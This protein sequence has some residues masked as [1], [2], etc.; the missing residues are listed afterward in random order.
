VVREIFFHSLIGLEDVDGE[1]DQALVGELFGTV[2]DQFGFAFA[3]F[4]PGGPELE[5]DDFTFERLVVEL[6]AGGGFGAEAR[7]GPLSS[8][9]KA[10]VR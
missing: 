3:V 8:A 10:R 5:Q 9:A 7:S 1:H 6:I 4:A 2:L